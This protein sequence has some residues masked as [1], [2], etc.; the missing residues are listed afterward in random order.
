MAG[1][2]KDPDYD[3]HRW[4]VDWK[5]DEPEREIVCN[6]GATLT[7]AHLFN[8]CPCG[9]HW[10]RWGHLVLAGKADAGGH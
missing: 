3:P 4:L 10:D 9:A 1:D 5:P 2:P 8:Q 6:C 7:L